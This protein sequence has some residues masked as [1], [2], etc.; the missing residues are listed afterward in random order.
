MKTCIDCNIAQPLTNYVPKASYK[1]GYEHRCRKCRSIR[2]NKSSPELLCKKL[3][4]SQVTNSVNRG[5]APP[6]YTLAEFTT[7][8]L[9]QPQFPVLYAAW[10]ASEY[11]KD[12]APSVDR[13]D[14]ASP[15]VINNLQL[16]TWT[17]NRAKA[18]ASRIDNTLLV[19]QRAVLAF[20][21]EGVLHKRYASMAE[22]MREF[23]GKAAQSWGISSVCNGTPVKDGKGYLY[24][25][26]TYKGF[27][28]KWE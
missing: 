18:H 4:T 17:E 26:K 9:A 25:P 12:L 11:N 13:I 16:M 21:K 15:Y 22:A 8:V 5:H 28:W 3:F 19:N 14:D 7:W 20:T 27:T 10:Q 24:T 1:G 2:Y 6:T 23:G